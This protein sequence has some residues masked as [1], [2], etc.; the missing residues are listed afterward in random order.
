MADSEGWDQPLKGMTP[1][2]LR[3]TPEAVDK[4]ADGVFDERT[5]ELTT[6]H[7]ESP[8]DHSD[9]EERRDIALD[10]KKEKTAS[11][12]SSLKIQGFAEMEESGV[13]PRYR[14]VL[15][16]DSRISTDEDSVDNSHADIVAE[17][18]IVPNLGRRSKLL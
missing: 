18:E 4:Y 10:R 14:D 3:M 15:R 16:E 7:R 11:S 17:D 13:S 8:V 6:H 1:V 9:V 12:S 5:V 2:T